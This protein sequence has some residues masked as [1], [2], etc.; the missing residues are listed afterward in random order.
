MST[1]SANIRFLRRA[2]GMSQ[3]ELAHA[4][5]FRS[6]TTVQKWESGGSMPSLATAADLAELFAVTLDDL[7]R[8]DF[9]D[10]TNNPDDDD[11][12]Y[13]DPEARKIAL[14]VEGHPPLRDLF[15]ACRDA[16]P[17]DIAMAAEMLR[18]MSRGRRNH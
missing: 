12:Y 6:L 18:R 11:V 3:A 5:G 9:A 16:A 4:L 8:H 17:E 7:V 15:D 14:K 13:I 1:L 2:A 10:P